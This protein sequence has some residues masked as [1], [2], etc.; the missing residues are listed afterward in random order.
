VVWWLTQWDCGCGGLLGYPETSQNVT[1]STSK[2]PKLFYVQRLIDNIQS[3]APMSA[4][5]ISL[6]DTAQLP[7]ELPTPHLT[8]LRVWETLDGLGV[9]PLSYSVIDRC[10]EY[11][12]GD[13]LSVVAVEH[14]TSFPVMR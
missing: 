3:P 2:T 8:L 13:W 10:A 4:V 1:P 11:D 7:G 6:K 14:A 12:V 9:L 5:Q